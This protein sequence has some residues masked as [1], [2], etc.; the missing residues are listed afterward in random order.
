[1]RGLFPPE[2]RIG[3]LIGLR[4]EDK[5]GLRRRIG[6]DGPSDSREGQHL[7]LG[8]TEDRVVSRKAEVLR[9]EEVTKGGLR[10]GA[11]RQPGAGDGDRG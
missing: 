10:V 4:R 9:L 1:M 6:R 5:L 11:V 8:P 3:V 7:G 2:R